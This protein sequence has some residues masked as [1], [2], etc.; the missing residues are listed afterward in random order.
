MSTFTPVQMAKGS[1]LRIA[2]TLEDYWN[3]IWAGWKPVSEYVPPEEPDY[4]EV[5]PHSHAAADIVDLETV[6]GTL[7]GE[8]SGLTEH[9]ANPTPHPEALSGRDFAAW[10]SAQKTP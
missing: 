8:A 1:R 9:I 5:G 3:Y 2:Y 7:V 6:V 10:Y 4:G